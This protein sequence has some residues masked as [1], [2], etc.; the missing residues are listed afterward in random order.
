M[1]LNHTSKKFQFIIYLTFFIK[2]LICFFLS[3]NDL[4]DNIEEQKEKRLSPPT[5]VHED[6]RFDILLA[7]ALRVFLPTFGMSN[8]RRGEAAASRVVGMPFEGAECSFEDRWLGITLEI[9]GQLVARHV[10]FGVA[11][12]NLIDVRKMRRSSPLCFRV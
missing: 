6:L 5:V 4:R 2:F 10:S 8:A 7:Y 11:V 1:I 9:L 3:S 12:M